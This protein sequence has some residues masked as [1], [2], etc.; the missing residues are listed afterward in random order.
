MT[1]RLGASADMDAVRIALS[2]I[3]RQGA[4][5]EFRARLRLQFVLDTIPERSRHERRPSRLAVL[6]AVA[7][8]GAMAAAFLLVVWLVYPGP[9]WK[10]SAVTGTG[11]AQV[12][13][14]SVPLE[15]TSLAPRLRP[16]TEIILPPDAQLDLELPGIAVMQIVGGSRA[17][18]PDRSSRWFTRSVTASL[19]SGELR[20]STGPGFAGTRLTVITP[21]IRAVVTG[22]T[23]AVLRNPDASCVCVLEGKVAMIG[24]GVSDT[25]R[26]GFRRSVFRNG[27]PPLLEPI[28]PMETMKLGMLR[29][30]VERTLGR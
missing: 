22:T 11:M 29:E 18:V 30:L 3:P 15:A 25:V 10:L 1:T 6:R 4:P 21:E 9:A 28:R 27:S 20:I 14:R 8:A 17:V 19:A 12:D 7:T 24:V 13:G 5:P 23:L 2:R 26:A 16:G